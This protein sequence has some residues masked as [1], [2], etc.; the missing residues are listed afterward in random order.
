MGNMIKYLLGGRR[1][2]QLTNVL[3][4]GAHIPTNHYQMNLAFKYTIRSLLSAGFVGCDPSTKMLELYGFSESLNIKTTDEGIARFSE[5][6]ESGQFY[7]VI[8]KVGGFHFPALFITDQESCPI[9]EN[10]LIPKEEAYDTLLEI[11][12]ASFQTENKLPID[13]SFIQ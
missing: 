2:G 13:Q 8:L 6:M 3:I 5:L 12:T 10:K 9:E 4:W 11:I 1:M 7:R